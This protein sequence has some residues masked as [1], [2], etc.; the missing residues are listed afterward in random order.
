MRLRRRLVAEPRP[1]VLI[2]KNQLDWLGIRASELIAELRAMKIRCE[3]VPPLGTKPARSRSGLPDDFDDPDAAIYAACV[4]CESTA[5]ELDADGKAVLRHYSEVF[6]RGVDVATEL[7]KRKAPSCVVIVQGYEMAGAVYR[8]AALRSGVPVLALENTAVKG[9]M[10]WDNVSGITTN[11]NLAKSYFWRYRESMSSSDA[12]GFC[13]DLIARTKQLKSS[14]HQSPGRPYRAGTGRPMV[15]FLGQ[16]YTDSSV[17]FDSAGWESPV[18]VIRQ[19][20]RWCVEHD[21]DLVIKLHPKEA[22]GR[23]PVTD[24]PYDQLTWRKLRADPPMRQ[25]LDDER[26]CVDHENLLD[27][28]SL[29]EQ[30]SFAV[31]VN[32]QSGLEAA[33]RGKPVVVCGNAFYSNLGFT[34]D[35][36]DPSRF[37]AIM[38]LPMEANPA[39]ARRFAAIFFQR[40]C[41]PQTAAAIAGL[42]A[43]TA[44]DGRRILDRGL[45]GIKL[46]S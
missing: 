1:P 35:T 40:Y 25:F 13:Q 15:L 39:E 9:R 4:T 34:V 41:R 27:T 10:L 2:P 14:E 45:S 21:R 3:K 12:D 19:L 24:K 37:Q 31:T 18:Q 46:A 11:R 6:R 29:M 30:C 32:S 28:Y 17:V 8:H 22:S 23:A 20:C 38:G 33:I 16:V 42:I 26:I 7:L 43:D 5:G 44:S 36:P